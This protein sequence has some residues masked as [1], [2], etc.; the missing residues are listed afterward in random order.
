[1]RWSSVHCRWHIERQER[2]GEHGWLDYEQKDVGNGAAN[3]LE[4]HRQAATRY[5]SV[6]DGLR[7][8]SNWSSATIDCL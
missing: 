8:D 5:V 1:M 7:A 3:C 2:I 6:S 4:T